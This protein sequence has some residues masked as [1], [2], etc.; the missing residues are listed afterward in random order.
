MVCDEADAYHNSKP[1]LLP[2]G[3]LEPV[4]PA[5][6]FDSNHLLREY[7]MR[8]DDVGC[9]ESDAHSSANSLLDFSHMRRKR[10]VNSSEPHVIPTK[11]VKQARM[12]HHQSSL[13][14][15]LNSDVRFVLGRDLKYNNLTVADG[16]TDSDCVV[17]CTNAP[18]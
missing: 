1:K 7:K 18:T 9:L 4:I 6:S 13:G 11:G 16:F 3:E 2:K 5:S 8:S 12:F 17:I 15:G 14:L 10:K